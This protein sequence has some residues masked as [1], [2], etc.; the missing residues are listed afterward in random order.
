MNPEV[1]G[2][3][4]QGRGKRRCREAVCHL[5]VLGL[6]VDGPLPSVRLADQNKEVDPRRGRVEAVQE[7]ELAGRVVPR[8]GVVPVVVALTDGNQRGEPRLRRVHVRLVG[9]G[10]ERVRHGVDRPGGV[11]AQQPPG[12]TEHQ[13]AE[14][15]LVVHVVRPHSRQAVRPG[16]VPERVALLLDPHQRVLH[17]VGAVDLLAG[18]LHGLALLQQQPTHV[19]VEEAPRDVVRVGL[20]VRLGV[21]HA[22]VPGPVVDGALVRHA[23][24]DHHHETRRKVCLVRAVRP[25]AVRARRDAEHARDRVDDHGLHPHGP[26]ERVRPRH[27][28]SPRGEAVRNHHQHHH[29]PVHV[30]PLPVRAVQLLHLLALLQVLQEVARRVVL[31]KQVA[32]QVCSARVLLQ[33]LQDQV[34][35]R[36]VDVQR[37]P[38]RATLPRRLHLPVL[39]L[40]ARRLDRLLQRVLR[41]LVLPEGDLVVALAAQLVP[42]GSVLV[43]LEDLGDRLRQL[44]VRHLR[45]VRRVLTGDDRHAEVGELDALLRPLLLHRRARRLGLVLPRKRGVEGRLDRLLRVLAELGVRGGRRDGDGGQQARLVRGGGVEVALVDALADALHVDEVVDQLVDGRDRLEHGG[46]QLRCLLLVLLQHLQKVEAALAVRQLAVVSVQVR[47]AR[48]QGLGA[49]VDVRLEDGEVALHRRS[50]LGEG[51]HGLRARGLAL[52]HGNLASEGVRHP[53]QKRCFVFPLVCVVTKC[54]CV[55]GDVNEVQI[56]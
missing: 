56:L 7:P 33:R 30:G 20:G 6:A 18:V 17:Q 21:V 31:V 9:T 22:V 8:V 36:R 15:R 25:E 1:R 26:E 11:Q 40:A 44:V 37:R 50:Q 43:L 48:G 45:Q 16:E 42:V 2:M 29:R 53:D 12:R 41:G 38:L 35:L 32:L 14:Q 27:D 49:H 55:G 46:V 28:D 47:V 23:V 5:G 51:G 10:A 39:R 24:G 54:V 52:A 3:Q 13:E 19:R 4:R 34:R